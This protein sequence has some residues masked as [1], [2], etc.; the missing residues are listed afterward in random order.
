MK[1]DIQGS[2]SISVQ[3]DI[4]GQNGRYVAAS[5]VKQP[6]NYANNGNL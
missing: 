1:P 6:Q 2:L 3:C 4:L 5:E